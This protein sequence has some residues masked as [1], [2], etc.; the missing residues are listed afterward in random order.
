MLSQPETHESYNWLADGG[1]ASLYIHGSKATFLRLLVHPERRRAGLGARLLETAV[2]RA[3]ERG[4]EEVH[5]HYVTAA[6]G[7]F[8]ARFGA[9][10]GQREVRSLLRVASA[11][12][13]PPDLPAGWRVLT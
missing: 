4:C 12:L 7:A 2:A 3:R 13:P 8:A 11:E 9:V 6:G 1:F 5:G 10:D